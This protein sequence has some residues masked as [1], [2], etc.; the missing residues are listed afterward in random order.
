MDDLNEAEER[1][2]LSVSAVHFLKSVS[3]VPDLRNFL[4]F[5]TM[6]EFKKI[7]H[8]EEK[9]AT[10][11]LETPIEI[12]L[13]W[14][15][16]NI[17]YLLQT[18]TGFEC[19]SPYTSV[20]LRIIQEIGD[21]LRDT[22]DPDLLNPFEEEKEYEAQKKSIIEHLLDDIKIRRTYRINRER[23]A[24]SDPPKHFLDQI[25]AKSDK[26]K[27][28]FL[29]QHL[30]FSTNKG[31]DRLLMFLT[32]R[33]GF[34]SGVQIERYLQTVYGDKYQSGDL[35]ERITKFIG[36]K[37]KEWGTTRDSSTSTPGKSTSIYNSE[38]TS[39]PNPSLNNPSLPNGGN[40]RRDTM[41]MALQQ[42]PLGVYSE[43]KMLDSGIYEYEED[44]I[45]E[46]G[47]TNIHNNSFRSLI[48]AAA[49]RCIQG[50]IE[51]APTKE[52]KKHAIE[53]VYIYIYI[54]IYSYVSNKHSDGL[55]SS[56]P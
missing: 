2:F 7:L 29:Q 16:K 47:E 32:G 24:W 44:K 37:E 41:K 30:V 15:G 20:A 39:T 17:E 5:N 38:S 45:E 54:Y 9:F 22:K 10:H 3:A 21:V 11:F 28:H 18:T 8:A 4:T 26:M 14:M 46:M 40:I 53:Q 34:G 51:F 55:P 35:E 13:S 12:E 49:L 33:T 48:I 42:E 27:E 19:L 6:L 25:N 31:I 23:K 50:A 52:S 56:V 1:R 43:E 36:E